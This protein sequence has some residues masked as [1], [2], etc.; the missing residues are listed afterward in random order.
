MVL[1][2]CGGIIIKEKSVLLIRRMNSR[3]VN[4]LW[5]NPGG[6]VEDGES[7]EDTCIRELS[8]ELGI[9]VEIIQ[10]LSDYEDYR[11]NE[12]FGRYTGFLV[13]I[14][15]GEPYRKEPDKIAE[16]RYWQLNKLP[17][18]IAPFTLQYLRDLGL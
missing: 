13:R 4:N 3:T 14:A 18:E 8:E 16:V 6:K 15:K 2:G 5:A 1:I 17:A 12:L 9:D 7:L 10:R 11:N